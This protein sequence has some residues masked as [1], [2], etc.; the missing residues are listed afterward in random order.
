MEDKYRY[1][2]NYRDPTLYQ[3]PKFIKKY[4]HT[5]LNGIPAH[6]DGQF[7]T[8][9]AREWLCICM[10]IL[11]CT[12]GWSHYYLGDYCCC[13]LCCC[14]GGQMFQICDLCCIID[15]K[16]EIYNAEIRREA[17]RV[18]DARQTQQHIQGIYAQQQNNFNAGQQVGYP[19]GPAYNPPYPTAQQSYPSAHYNQQDYG[20]SNENRQ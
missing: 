16:V 14:C 4:K 20:Y 7:N 6:G 15:D 19:A 3:D 17:H 8:F 13:C 2:F 9:E 10:G 11:P 18:H 5:F 12:A 1:Q